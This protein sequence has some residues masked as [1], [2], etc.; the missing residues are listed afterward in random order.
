MPQVRPNK[1]QVPT[2]SDAFTNLNTDLATMADTINTPVIVASQA[3]RDGLGWTLAAGKMV[4]RTDLNRHEYYDGAAW[5]ELGAP[6][7]QSVTTSDGTWAY[8]CQLLTYTTLDGFKYCSFQMIVARTSGG[9]FT[10]NTG[11]WT[12]LFTSLIPSGY[13]PTDS[14]TVAGTYEFN[15]LGAALFKVDTSGNLSACGVTGSFSCGTPTKLSASFVWK[16][17]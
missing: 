3:E 7:L 2:N 4:F 14:I 13:R 1:V 10:V 11:A 9:A 8:N 16:C 12:A 5:R 15:G 17:A 6:S